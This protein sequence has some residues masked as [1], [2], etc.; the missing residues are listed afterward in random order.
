MKS[1]PVPRPMGRPRKPEDEYL[2][3]ITLR[4]TIDELTKLK[5][6]GGRHWVSKRL[7][8]AKVNHA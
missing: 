8:A 1:T 5:A 4:F 6:L 7:K 3:A 2:H